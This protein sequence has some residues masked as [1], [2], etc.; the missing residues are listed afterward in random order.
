MQLHSN[1]ATCPR[2]RAMIKNSEL[3]YRVLAEQLDISV[4]TVHHWKHQESPQDKSCRPHTTHY[5]LG[6]EESELALWM[7]RTGEL[8]L[9]ELHESLE[10]LLPGVTRSSLHRLLVRHDCSRL[11]KKEQQPTGQPGTFKEYGPGYVHIDCFYLPKLEGQK[12]Y[13]FVAID[14]AT[15]LVYLYVYENKNK[16]CATDFLNRCLEFFPF[17]VEKILTDNGREFTLAGFKNRWGSET[18]SVHPFEAKCAEEKIEH[19]KTRP[20]TPKTNGM[21]ERANGLTKENTTKKNRYT[22]AQEMKDDLARWRS[23]YNFDR[24]NRRIGRKT[25][26]QMACWWYQKQPEIFLKEPFHLLAYRS[27]A[28]ET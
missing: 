18:K 23:F 10:E 22:S 11:P 25:P 6:V 5:A 24:R 20:Y 8:P 3:P 7:R 27:Q 16:E 4:A 21:V 17:K 1:A 2:Q 15:R 26:Y 9:D 14:R 28:G 19:R 13:C 12:Y